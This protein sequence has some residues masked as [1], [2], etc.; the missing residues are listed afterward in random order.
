MRGGLAYGVSLVKMTRRK[1]PPPTEAPRRRRPLTRDRVLDAAMKLAD[2]SGVDG[3]SMR[4]LASRLGVEAMSL[5]KHVANK[6]EVL[7]GLGDRV[8]GEI[9]MPP[10]GTPWREGMRARA[11]AA[12]ATFRR[13]PW[14]APLVESRTRMSPVRLGYVE[15]VLGLLCDDGFSPMRASRA[16]LLV[17]SFLYG[18]TV[19]EQAWP[20]ESPD[21]LANLDHMAD[22]MGEAYPNLAQV[23]GPWMAEIK[24][25]GVTRV[26]DAAFDFGLEQVLDCL[27]R[28]RGV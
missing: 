14:A 9:E 6:D 3:L 15:A 4:K 23:M 19:H 21:E 11:H 5:Y 8:I 18:F 13:H 12:R 16:F 26:H 7:D 22:E 2:K 10:R 28:I 20:F 1:S 25:V 17:D 27:E 24:A